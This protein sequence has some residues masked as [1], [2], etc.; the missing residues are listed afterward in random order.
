MKT[1]PLSIR[2]TEKLYKIT[3]SIYLFYLSSL[4]FPSIWICVV[5]LL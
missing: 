4:Y 2:F 1:F 5:H 3:V